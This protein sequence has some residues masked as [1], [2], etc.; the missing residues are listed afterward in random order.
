MPSQQGPHKIHGLGIQHFLLLKSKVTSLD[1]ANI[2]QHSMGL[3]IEKGAIR[4]IRSGVRC[5]YGGLFCAVLLG[6]NSL[7][8]HFKSRASIS[9]RLAESSDQFLYLLGISLNQVDTSVG[10]VE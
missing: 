6:V 1:A 3:D 2:H 5:T 7:L 9:L 8:I 4:A 10:D